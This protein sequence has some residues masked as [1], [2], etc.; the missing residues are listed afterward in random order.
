MHLSI[1]A[2]TVNYLKIALLSYI[3][4][5]LFETD[6]QKWPKT[7]PGIFDIFGSGTQK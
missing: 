5:S 7:A 2:K 3:M 4:S 1:N 6:I